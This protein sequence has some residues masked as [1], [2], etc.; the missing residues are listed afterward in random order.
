MDLEILVSC[1]MV[2]HGVMVGSHAGART[3]YTAGYRYTV[4]PPLLPHARQLRSAFIT[5]SRLKL[6]HLPRARTGAAA[7]RK[8]QK[9]ARCLGPSWP[10]MVA[11][12]LY[13]TQAPHIDR[14]TRAEGRP[15]TLWICKS[16]N[17][18]LDWHIWHHRREWGRRWGNN[19]GRPHHASHL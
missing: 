17:V 18:G 8:W 7:E 10:N 11:W 1:A 3:W 12:Q 5:D 19:P 13:S 16:W 4:C 2:R 9:W 15:Q 6:Q 14:I